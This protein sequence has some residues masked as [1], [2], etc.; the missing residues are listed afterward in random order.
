MAI[1][2]ALSR[3]ITLLGVAALVT[4]ACSAPQGTASPAP[5]EPTTVQQSSA[6]IAGKAPAGSP[7]PGLPAPAG[8]PNLLATDWSSR[9]GVIVSDLKPAT[10][11]AVLNPQPGDL[12]FFSNTSTAWGATNTKNGIWVIDAKTKKTVAEI[13]PFDGLNNS[14]HGLAVSGDGKFIYLPML[15][16]DNRIDVL[17]G[18]TF[19]VVQTIHTL[20]RNH[21]MKLWHSAAT[22]KDYILGEDFNSSGGSGMYIF[23]PSQN[24]AVVGGMSR[25]DFPGNPYVTAP[26]PDGKFI[27]VTLPAPGGLGSK[28]MAGLLAKV[29]PKTWTVAGLTPIIGALWPQVSLDSKYA[30]VTSG[31]Q[32]RVHKVNLETMVDEGFVQTGPGPWGA[33]LSYDGTLLYT[34]DK[35]EGPGYNQQ[36]R[37]ST[38]IDLQTM[39]VIAALPIGLTTDHALLSPDGEEIWFTS[40]AEH[41]ITIY[42]AKTNTFKQVVTDPADGDIHGGVWVQYKSDGKGGVIAEVVADYA[43]LHGSALAAQLE[44]AASPAITIA[45]NGSGFTQKTANVPAGKTVRVTIKNIGGTSGGKITFDSAG[46]GVTGL[47]LSA[48]ESKEI[49]FKAPAQPTDITAKVNKTPNGD[50][51][52]KVAVPAVAPNQGAATTG[53]REILLSSKGFQFDQKSIEVKVG[54]T[55]KITFANGDEEKHNF[56]S[57]GGGGLLSPDVAGGAKVSFTYGAPATPGTF[58][59]ICAYHPQ[60]TLDLVIK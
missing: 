7:A 6:P 11:K 54:E 52:I 8:G 31:A 25:G 24:N 47:T 12:Y 15:G 16:S 17:D 50:L 44:Y 59:V 58:K 37:T 51:T 9:L 10:G 5:K 36:G 53:P 14:S 33:G 28:D 38:V 56:V 3:G 57:V 30:Y 18:R 46:L 45:F 40:N 43:G 13:S 39:G 22:N 49:Q 41:N 32:A 48:G 2:R 1:H 34:A 60:T 27:V 42:N 21:H 29:D 35:G 20:S 4:F 23:D 19:E 26:T 55:V